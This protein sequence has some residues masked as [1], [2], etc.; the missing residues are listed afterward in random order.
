M[1]WSALGR[2]GTAYVDIRHGVLGLCWCPEHDTQVQPGRNADLLRQ[3]SDMK[4]SS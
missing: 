1:H 3:V 2:H 4:V